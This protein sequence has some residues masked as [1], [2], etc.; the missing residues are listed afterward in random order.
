MPL[1]PNRQ[2]REYS[3]GGNGHPCTT[4]LPSYCA[5]LRRAWLWLGNWRGWQLEVASLPPSLQVSSN[6]PWMQIWTVLQ[7]HAT[8]CVLVI[9]L[10]YVFSSYFR[11]KSKTLFKSWA[12]L[13]I[14][15]KHHSGFPIRSLFELGNKIT[16]CLRIKKMMSSKQRE[17]N[18]T[19]RR[20]LTSRNEEQM[21]NTGFV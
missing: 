17:I 9:Q 4:A 18:I 2:S 20:S 6:C 3:L 11:N 10:L 8:K 12:V 1:R 14:F 19:S 16:G 15:T 5:W 13:W 7:P 21:I